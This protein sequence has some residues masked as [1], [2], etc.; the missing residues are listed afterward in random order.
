MIYE[1][2]KHP[3]QVSLVRD[4]SAAHFPPNSTSLKNH[5]LQHLPR[6]NSII[7]ETLRLHPAVPTALPRLTPPEGLSI[8]NT[9][10]PGDT[11]FWCPQ[12][13]IGRS[14]YL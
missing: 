2:A 1:L 3:E 6:L 8:G 12:Y 5:D 13:A 10:I 9:F 14:M 4:E 11:V 7:Y